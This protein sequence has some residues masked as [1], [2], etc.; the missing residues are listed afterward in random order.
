MMSYGKVAPNLRGIIHGA[1]EVTIV[2]KL[3]II[4]ST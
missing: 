3:H 2:D 1:H 4:R